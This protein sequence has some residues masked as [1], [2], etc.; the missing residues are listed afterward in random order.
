MCRAPPQLTP[1]CN[2]IFSILAIAICL[3]DAICH[4]MYY[5]NGARHR[6]AGARPAGARPAG[7]RPAGARP[8]GARRRRASMPVKPPRNARGRQTHD[9]GGGSTG[10]TERLPRRLCGPPRG[11]GGPGGPGHGHEAITR[12]FLFFANATTK[13]VATRKS[14]FPANAT[15]KLFTLP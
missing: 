8:A 14:L 11:G 10:Y 4:N 3:A 15:T 9:V 1:D 5:A 12:K 6:P 13:S 7:A 2:T